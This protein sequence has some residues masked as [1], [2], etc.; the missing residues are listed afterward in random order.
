MLNS[1]ADYSSNKINLLI[2]KFWPGPLTLILKKKDIVPYIVT[3]GLDTVAV[4]MP[5][6]NSALELIKQL[7]KPMIAYKSQ[8]SD[9]IGIDWADNI[10]GILLFLDKYI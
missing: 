9:K 10:E 2:D 4:R 1:V 3:A 5:K 8:W 6:S 7:G